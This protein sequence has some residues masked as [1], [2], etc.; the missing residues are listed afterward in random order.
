MIHDAPL[1]RRRHDGAQSVHSR[2]AGAHSS[3]LKKP[4]KEMSPIASAEF[5]AY[6]HVEMQSVMV[7]AN[8]KAKRRWHTTVTQPLRCGIR[9]HG[10]RTKKKGELEYDRYEQSQGMGRLT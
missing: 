5:F 2:S 6:S 7:L 8:H 9:R 1:S 10:T 4:K 3:F